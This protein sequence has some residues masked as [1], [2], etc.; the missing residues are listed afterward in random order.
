VALADGT[1]NEVPGLAALRD[2]VQ[3]PERMMAPVFTADK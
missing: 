2:L 3:Q 1:V